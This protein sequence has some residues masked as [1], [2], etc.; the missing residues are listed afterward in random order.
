MAKPEDRLIG[1]VV[2]NAR[3]Q[4]II[5]GGG[6]GVVYRA[7]QEQLGAPVAVKVIR[8]GFGEQ[9]QIAARF[10]REAR[11]IA[12]LRGRTPYVVQIY[13]FG[14]DEATGAYYITMELVEGEGADRLLRR[15]VRLPETA[16]ARLVRQAASGLAV[17]H[18]AGI[19]HRDIKPENLLVAREGVVKITDFGLAKRLGA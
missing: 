3:I 10:E 13:D 16:A 8:H 5:G 6:M 2:G 19:V 12:K 17:A 9:A 1:R 15:H 7:V 4:S 14:R 18:A 11:E